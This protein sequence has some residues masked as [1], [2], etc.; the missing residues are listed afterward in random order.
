MAKKPN[1]RRDRSGRA[2]GKAQ[3]WPGQQ[4]A[5]RRRAV[6][7]PHDVDEVDDAGRDD[8]VTRVEPPTASTL[9]AEIRRMADD[10]RMTPVADDEPDPGGPAELEQAWRLYRALVAR[11]RETLDALTAEGE[12]VS[13][14]HA[15]LQAATAA[16]REEREMFDDRVRVLGRREEEL[17]DREQAAEQR[18]DELRLEEGRKLNAW[19]AERRREA[20]E[21]WEAD[22]AAW[23]ERWTETQRRL[24]QAQTVLDR[25]EGE[26]AQRERDLT[27]ER[28][29]LDEERDDVAALA[30]ALAEQRRTRAA[31]FEREVA[32]RVSGFVQEMGDPQGRIERLTQE[33]EQLR[34]RLRE[35]ETSSAALGDLSPEQ[36][37]ARIRE[38]RAE[39]ALLTEDRAFAPNTDSRLVGQL[40]E[41]IRV[42]NEEKEE[43]VSLRGELESALQRDR[44]AVNERENYLEVNNWLHAANSQLRQI[45][46]EE[47][48]KLK[49]TAEAGREV[50][51]FP[52]CSL[53]DRDFA[54]P[55]P[56]DPHP[57]RLSELA[58]R[59]QT[60]IRAGT[61]LS[62][63]LPDLRL[64]LAGL[65]MSRLHVFQGISGIGKTGLGCALATGFGS[66][67][68]VAVVPVQSGWRDP[69]DLMGYY[70]S[71]DRMFY[72][73]EFTKA[74]YLAGCPAYRD[75]P[76]FIVLDE[77]NLSHPEQ[78]F[79]GVLSALA[80]EGKPRLALTTMPVDNAPQL[81]LGGTH[82]AIPD[83][84]WFIGTANHDET[85]VGFA[86]KT[87]DRS[88]VLELPWQHPELPE[89]TPDPAEPLAHLGLAQAFAQARS[90]HAA[91]AE[92]IIAFLDKAWRRRFA[93][94]LGIGWGNRLERQ[95][96]AFAPVLI[97]AGGTRGA[98]LDH[99][100]ATRILRPLRGR[101]DIDADRLDAVRSEL[102]DSLLLFDPNHEPVA[103]V[104]LLD[105][106][107]RSQGRR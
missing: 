22:R 97:A 30:A 58:E 99:L 10:A 37:A 87:Y 64:V 70:N 9:L 96:R 53:M 32:E 48:A 60:V 28:S 98:A 67:D 91:E 16:L 44:I 41:R 51:A 78:Y 103:T 4:D 84:V 47:A 43:L 104:R 59:L 88:F 90:A 45:L 13:A 89:S 2:P 6:T 55:R 19:L 107:M 11:Q 62:Y 86:A 27:T 74:L 26:L 100:L 8:E 77:M 105:D 101:Y 54:R 83:N 102:A 17:A 35:Y 106:E 68:S 36:A 73:S 46:G 34:A 93:E 61:G 71:F 52:A 50:H 1:T 57:P 56:V 80:L 38:L 7:S 5:A 3:V 31:R 14:E 15:A 20:V 33:T 72:E 85:T 63:G 81:F 79:S 66:P 69:Q 40:R 12:R 21:T 92:G 29:R 49:A 42:L 39:V 94:E 65:A 18:F 82:I 95:I 25:R 76:F 23:Q 24:S 75:R